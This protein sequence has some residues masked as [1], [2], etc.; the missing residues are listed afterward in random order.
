MDWVDGPKNYKGLYGILQLLQGSH[1]DNFPQKTLKLGRVAFHS[2][3]FQF[4]CMGFQS[5]QYKKLAPVPSC[6]CNGLF[7]STFCFRGLYQAHAGK[8]LKG[9]YWKVIIIGSHVR[10]GAPRKRGMFGGFGKM[11]GIDCRRFLR[12]PHPLPLLL[13]FCIRSQFRSLRVRFC[14]RLLHRIN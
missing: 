6:F 11:S 13:I 14:K 4:Q 3:T 2:V 1:L 7:A 10:V 5:N 8:L 12:S 9:I